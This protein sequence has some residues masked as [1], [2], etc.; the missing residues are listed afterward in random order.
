MLDIPDKYLYNRI[1]S[2]HMEIFMNRPG[3]RGFTLIE[4]SLVMVILGIM[5]A[6]AL[7]KYSRVVA[8]NDLEK[9]ANNVYLEIR[10]M[11]P[12]SF[13][14]DGTA[15]ARFNTVASQ[16]TLWVDTSGEDS[17]WYKQVTLL[18]LPASVKM[19]TPL[20]TPSSWK[21]FSPNNAWK[22]SLRV[23]SDSR[24]EYDHGAIYL[25]TP[26]LP[27]IMYCVGIAAAMQS[28]ELHKWDGKTWTTNSL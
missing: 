11:R 3:N 26:K 2:N 12:L 7:A 20:T 23:V 27:K 25:F 4:I 22:D 21:F 24:G 16:C 6:L 13:K 14:Y 9:A 15:R 17:L 19:G 1:T 5:A 10:S 18:Q 28:V 8:A